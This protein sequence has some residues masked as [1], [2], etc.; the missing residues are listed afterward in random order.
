MRQCARQ[1]QYRFALYLRRM[2]GQH[3]HNHDARHCLERIFG[4]HATRLQ[5]CQ[6]ARQ[7]PDLR[8]RALQTVVTTTANLM[9]VFGNIGQQ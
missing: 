8:L 7:R 9:H 5:I 2:R 3:R 1:I 4:R 6:G